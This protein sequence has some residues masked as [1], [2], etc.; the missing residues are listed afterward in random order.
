MNVFKR[1]KLRIICIFALI[2]SVILFVFPTP[3]GSYS[4]DEIHNGIIL[5][6]SRVYIATDSVYDRGLIDGKNI[7]YVDTPG[8]HKYTLDYGD[9]DLTIRFTILPFKVSDAK[10]IL[11]GIIFILT[12]FIYF[13]DKHKINIFGKYYEL[14]FNEQ[15]R[16]ESPLLT[17][18]MPF[19]MLFVLLLF[20]G[21]SIEKLKISISGIIAVVLMFVLSA[22]IYFKPSKKLYIAKAILGFLSIA[23]FIALFEAINNT[24]A[25]L[26]VF[27]DFQIIIRPILYM[28]IFIP[29]YFILNLESR[30]YWQKGFAWS[31]VRTAL[32]GALFTII[33]Y[34]IL[35]VIV[36]LFIL[37]MFTIYGPPGGV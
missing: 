35:Q 7:M 16:T 25:S 36:I 23:L 21:L 24:F 13:K 11:F 32:K 18:L 26:F 30:L 3:K 29:F 5:Q 19:Y 22:I 27:F 15:L 4:I 14:N 33:D 28:I 8:F 6:H 17:F 31:G 9:V 1:N 20:S 34:V 12:L 2:F 37:V 10:E